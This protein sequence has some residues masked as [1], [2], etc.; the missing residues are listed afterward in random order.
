MKKNPLFRLKKIRMDGG[1]LKELFWGYVYRRETNKPFS[2]MSANQ[3]I[4]AF[5]LAESMTT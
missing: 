5:W 4:F 2:S 3:E 1:D